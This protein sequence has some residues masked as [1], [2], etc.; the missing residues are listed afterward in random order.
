MQRNAREGH[1]FIKVNMNLLLNFDEGL[2][3]QVRTTPETIIPVLEAATKK[4]FHNNYYET[5][6]EPSDPVPEWQVQI[7]SDE[8]PRILRDLTSNMV[9]KLIVVPGIITSASRTSIKA[10]KITWKCSACDHTYAQDLKFGFGGAQARRQCANASNPI[11]SERSRC[12]LDPYK[13]VAEKCI[14]LD[15]QT[16]KLQEAPEMIPTGE[17]PRT[18]VVTVDRELTDK[19]TPGNRVKLVGILGIIAQ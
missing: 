16:L 17:M 19:V 6:C 18:F 2:A 9:G 13:I 8:N 10:T 15:Q 12:P 3:M 7:F 1:F 4:V 11:S 14:F 5:I